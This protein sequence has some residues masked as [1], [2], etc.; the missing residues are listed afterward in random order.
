MYWLEVNVITDGEGAEAVAEELRPFA[1]NDGVVLE[2]LG[3]MN[4]PDLDALDTA[5]T[6]K[7][8]LPEDEDTPQNRRRI[9]EVIYHL[10]RLYPIP[11]VMGPIVSLCELKLESSSSMIMATPTPPTLAWTP[12]AVPSRSPTNTPVNMQNDSNATP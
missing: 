6:V 7:I 2:Q 11:P 12:I 4:S 1:Y 10:G 3:D 5:V 9:E 8:Y